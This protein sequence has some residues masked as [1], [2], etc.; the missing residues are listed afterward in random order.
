MDMPRV[1]TRYILVTFVINYAVFILCTIIELHLIINWYIFFI[2]LF[3]EVSLLC[4]GDRQRNIMV[5][6]SGV[7]VGLAL[8]LF[9]RNVTAIIMKVPLSAFDNNFSLPGNAKQYPIALG[10]LC[11]GLWLFYGNAPAEKHENAGLS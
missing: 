9:F 1:K 5:A 8:N 7:L 3:V 6:L 11:A 4:R 10:F 2:C